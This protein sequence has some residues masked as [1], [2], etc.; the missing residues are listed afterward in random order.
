MIQRRLGDVAVLIRG[1]T[2]KPDQKCDPHAPQAVACM[3]T[4]NVQA[5]L[6]QSDLIGVPRGLVK[7]KDKIIGPGDT[8]VSS[9][10]SWNLVGKCCQVPDLGYP[11]TAGGF[12]SILR[13]TTDELDPTYLYRWFSSSA[14]QRAVRSFGNQT[15]NISNLNHKRTLD[16]RI[17]LPTLAEQKRIAK[18]LDAAD[19]LRARRRESLDQLDALLQSTFLEMFGDPVTNPKGWDVKLSEELFLLRPRIGTTKSAMGQGHLVVRVGE[20]G[21]SRIAFERCGRVELSP[22]DV[23]KYRLESGDTVIA[24]AIGSKSQLGKA[25]FFDGYDEEVVIDSHVMRL[26]PNPEKCNGRWLYTL[27][28]SEQGKSLL[29][30]AGG[31]TAVQ[32]NINSKQA[33]SLDLPSPPVKLQDQFT[34]IV[35]SIE[36]QKTRLRA[37]LAELDA[38]FASLQARAFA[39]EL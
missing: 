5:Q 11:A 4:K 35:E 3:R 30:R 26:R 37:H 21:G 34:T 1:I 2:F 23:E 12:I 18:I 33:S 20:L 7:N 6:E 10:N 16:L 8:L 31:A 13:S 17:P 14:I 39:G 19:A 25:S 36:Q 32:F 38:L 27:I 24:R 22:K 28:S 29:L 15:T 9:A